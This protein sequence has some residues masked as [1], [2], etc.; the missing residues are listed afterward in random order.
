MS[1]TSGA[2]AAEGSTQLA[3]FGGGCFWCTE[4]VFAELVGVEQVLPG[5]AG[6]GTAN[7]SY[8]QVCAGDTGHAEVIQIRFRPAEISYRDLLRVFFTVHDPTTRNRQGADVGTQYRS[9]VLFHSEAQHRQAEEVRA[10]IDSE[11][12]WSKAI[13]TEMVPFREF[14]PAEEYHRE[15]YRRHPERSYCQIVIAPKVAKF[16]KQYLD[17]LKPRASAAPPRLA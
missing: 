11:R 14:Y 12:L 7:P 10:E 4:A 13:V 16:R 2:S 1:G 9:I 8:E 15:Y 17:R 3:T 5:Y 6:G